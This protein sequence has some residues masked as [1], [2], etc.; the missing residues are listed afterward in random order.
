MI[1]WLFRELWDIWPLK[2]LIM[3][4]I[5]HGSEFGAHRINKYGL[6]GNE[7]KRHNEKLGISEYLQY[8]TS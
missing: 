1:E 8:K 7:F 3:D 4:Q 6:W 5:D 2:K